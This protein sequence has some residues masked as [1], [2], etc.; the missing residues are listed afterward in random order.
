MSCNLVNQSQDF[1]IMKEVHKAPH[2]LLPEIDS[3]YTK[4]DDGGS[5]PP[6]RT[7]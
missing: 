4:P 1:Y 7:N 3:L 5:N 6:G 2:I